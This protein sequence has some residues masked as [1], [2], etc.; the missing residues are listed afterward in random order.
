M[1]RR[2]SG[3]IMNSARVSTRC[4]LDSDTRTLGYGG[5][6]KIVIDAEVCSRVDLG[7]F[8]TD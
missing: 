2:I 4:V 1:T 8:V 5:R 6:W 7:V 3:C